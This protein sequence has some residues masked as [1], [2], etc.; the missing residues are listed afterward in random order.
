M[1][2]LRHQ[3]AVVGRQV[4]WPRYSRPTGW[5][6]R[7]WPGCRPGTAGGSSWWRSCA[8]TGSWWPGA[9]PTR[10]PA[11]PGVGW[12]TTWSS[13]PG[14]RCIGL[15][16]LLCTCQARPRGRRTRQPPLSGT[17]R[18][19]AGC[20]SVGL[21]SAAAARPPSA[22]GST[23]DDLILTGAIG[24]TGRYAED[25][26]AAAGGLRG[27]LGAL[28]GVSRAVGRPGRRA[29]GVRAGRAVRGAGLG[30][31]QAAAG[32]A[33][34]SVAGKREGVAAWHAGRAPGADR[35]PAGRDAAAG[36]DPDR[37]RR[38]CTRGWVQPGRAATAAPPCGT[39]PTP[40]ALP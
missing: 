37:P 34:G 28:G 22:A 25:G 10:R 9:G 33:A 27:T 38:S 29:R 40:R 31:G 2:V 21:T 11:V 13:R 35:G 39:S 26:L 1:A 19:A 8:G 24:Q 7:G 3:L 17:P 32:S 30:V 18:D 20:T 14:G 4:A 36:R 12:P 6:W 5:C 23:G 15:P 16:G